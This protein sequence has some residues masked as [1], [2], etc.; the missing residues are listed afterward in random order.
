MK[1]YALIYNSCLLVY[2]FLPAVEERVP[3]WQ[4][5]APGHALPTGPARGEA[6]GAGQCVA[7][8]SVPAGL[9]FAPESVGGK[10]PANS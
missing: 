8:H 9:H 2:L 3:C 10:D 5:D 1:V 6:Q 7:A 4:V